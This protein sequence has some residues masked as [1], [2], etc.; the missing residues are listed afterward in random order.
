M[1]NGSTVVSGAASQSLPLVIGANIITAKVIGQDGVTTQTYTITVTRATSAVATLS[2]LKPSRGA[3]NP[4]FSSATTSYT[5]S[6]VNGVTSMTLTPTTTSPAATV[7]VNGTVVASGSASQSIPLVVGTTTIPVKVTAQ[8]GTTIKIY[9]LVVTRAKSSHVYMANLTPSAGA[10]SPTFS[11][12]KTAY[13]EDVVNG[14]ASITI[15]PVTAVPTSTVK[16]NG[17]AVT[18]GTASAP[19]ALNVGANTITTVVTAQDGVTT[20]TY[21]LTVTRAEVFG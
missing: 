1:V 18:S 6:V 8:D 11:A 15:T 3:L 9:T 4:A 16:V 2:S 14:A 20:K 19:I 12:S 13:T 17:T 7:K 21:T 10:L 5:A